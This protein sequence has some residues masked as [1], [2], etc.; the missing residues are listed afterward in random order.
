M[1]TKNFILARRELM[2]RLQ[3]RRAR[4][5]SNYPFRMP[6]DFGVKLPTLARWALSFASQGGAISKMMEI[7]IPLAIPF[8]FRKKTSFM[9]RLLSRFVP[10][11]A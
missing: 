6:D 10:P 2:D 1:D 9:G 11:K 4:E 7:G 5:L 3:A 8:L